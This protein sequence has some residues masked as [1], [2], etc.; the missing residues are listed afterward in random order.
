MKISIVTVC[1][2]SAATIRDAVD[3]ISAQSESFAEY[4]KDHGWQQAAYV[5][6]LG[7]DP[8]SFSKKKERD[9]G[10]PLRLVYIGA[11]GRSYDLETLLDTVV[12]L[13]KQGMELEL[14]FAGDGEKME[15]L[16]QSAIGAGVGGIHFHGYLNPKDLECLLQ[17][18]D[19]GVVPMYPAS[20][21]SIPYKAGDYLAAGLPIVN[22]L[23]GDLKRLLDA[24]HCGEY[25]V[26]GDP[27]SLKRAILKY[28]NHGDERLEAHMASAGRLYELQF[29]RETIYPRFAEWVT[30]GPVELQPS[31]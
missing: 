22:S 21:V 9:K 14:H 20:G 10:Q 18:C 4:A 1:Y 13:M 3:S 24:H 15:L 29:N 25:Y 26:A 5:C 7:A 27:E 12:A 19:V 16:R 17:S 23:T 30:S 2:N 6:Y 8:L 28:M 11:M 31:N